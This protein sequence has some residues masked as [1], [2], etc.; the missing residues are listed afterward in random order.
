MAVKVSVW[1]TVVAASLVLGGVCVCCVP[2]TI[3]QH[4]SYRIR[5]KIPSYTLWAVITQV[6]G[7]IQYSYEASKIIR[8]KVASHKLWAMITQVVGHFCDRKL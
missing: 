6:E 5:G 7:H 3:Y 2:H 4:D 8:N 1:V